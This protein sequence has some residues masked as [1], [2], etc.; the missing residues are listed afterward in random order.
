MKYIPETLQMVHMQQTSLDGKMIANPHTY[1]TTRI[2]QF[3]KA[4]NVTIICCYYHEE[5]RIKANGGGA[6]SCRE[7]PNM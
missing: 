7:I 3:D 5:H 6:P 2:G 4:C 1:I